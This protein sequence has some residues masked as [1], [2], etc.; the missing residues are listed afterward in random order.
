MENVKRKDVIK[1]K[2]LKINLETPLESRVFCVSL[3]ATMKY[4]R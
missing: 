3:K 2:S 1:N 4:E